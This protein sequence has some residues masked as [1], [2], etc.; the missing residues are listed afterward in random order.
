MMTAKAPAQRM[1]RTLFAALQRR[2]TNL[3]LAPVPLPAD[4]MAAGRLFSPER[5]AMA[6]NFAAIGFSVCIK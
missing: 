2:Y 4:G 3:L 5:N 6:G 1:P